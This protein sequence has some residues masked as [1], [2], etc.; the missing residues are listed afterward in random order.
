MDKKFVTLISVF[1]LVFVLFISLVAFNE[2][3]KRFTRASETVHPSGETSILFAWPQ[4]TAADGTSKVKLEVFVRSMTGNPLP[5]KQVS[6]QS[7]LGT[8]TPLTLTSDKSGKASFTLTATTP[9]VATLSALIDGS[10]SVAKKVTV[11]FE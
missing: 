2:P 8:I 7:T 6:V 10:T 9:G 11:K 1:V 3:I 4:S 5:N